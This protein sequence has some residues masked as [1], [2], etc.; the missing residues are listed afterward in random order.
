[1][2]DAAIKSAPDNAP[3]ILKFIHR[4]EIM[5]EPQRNGRQQQPTFP[6]SVVLHR[7]I[8]GWRRCILHRENNFRLSR[9]LVINDESN[10]ISPVRSI[11]LIRV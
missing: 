7:F 9:K 5:P 11:K 3:A 4:P 1:M 8:S 2:R 10:F 6:A